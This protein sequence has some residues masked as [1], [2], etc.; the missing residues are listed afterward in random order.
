MNCTICKRPVDE[1]GLKKSLYLERF[2]SRIYINPD[3]KCWEWMGAKDS[4]GYGSMYVHCRM[5]RT[6]HLA[7]KFFEDIIVPKNLVLMHLCHNKICCNPSHLEIGTYSDNIKM[8]F[9]DG[10]RRYTGFCEHPGEKN[11]NAK[12]KAEDIPKIRE[13]RKNGESYVSIAKSFNVDRTAIGFICRG[14]TWRHI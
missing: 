4:A 7:L 8:D 6:Q 11:V 12:L 9:R 2:Y 1:H 3:N 5:Q 14:Q 13:R 10:R